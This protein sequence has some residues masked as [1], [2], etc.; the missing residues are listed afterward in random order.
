MTCEAPEGGCAA[1]LDLRCP[2]KEAVASPG[3]E[4][5]A[6]EVAGILVRHAPRYLR[7]EDVPPHE[8]L[9][10]R[11]GCLREALGRGVPDDELGGYVDRLLE[12]RIS[13]LCLLELPADG[14]TLADLLA[15]ESLEVG[16]PIEVRRFYRVSL[17]D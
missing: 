9:G 5:L 13:R 6:R 17:E 2:S 3:F 14:G 11:Q 1:L 12:A 16:H 10:L 15:R 4:A 8:L 7:R